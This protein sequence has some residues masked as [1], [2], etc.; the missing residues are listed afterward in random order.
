M[1]PEVELA[2]YRMAQEA[3]TNARK[4]A[5]AQRVQ[6]TVDFTP[7]S[8]GFTV[9]DDGVGF[10]VPEMPDEFAHQGHFGLLGLTERAELIGAELKVESQPGHGTRV[11]VTFPKTAVLARFAIIQ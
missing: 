7:E 8:V 4:H 11:R 10:V 1:A 6:L 3:L 2:L 5:N 9:Q